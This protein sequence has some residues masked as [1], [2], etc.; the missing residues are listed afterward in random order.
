MQYFIDNTQG[1]EYFEF[2]RAQAFACAIEV[3]ARSSNLDVAFNL[4][5]RVAQE[6]PESLLN[7]QACG[8]ILC[9][10]FIRRLLDAAIPSS[11]R[12]LD[13]VEIRKALGIDDSVASEAYDTIMSMVKTFVGQENECPLGGMTLQKVLLE[14]ARTAKKS[15]RETASLP[16]NSGQIVFRESVSDA[17]LERAESCFQ[18]TLPPEYKDFL[19]I[20]NGWDG[21]YSRLHFR[22][23]YTVSPL[24]QNQRSHYHFRLPASRT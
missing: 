6:Q 10:H 13:L 21:E 22:R 24:K 2:R 14:Y 23:T 3:A 17:Q 9:R 7:P 20:S 19:R 1:K 5:K 18:I 4:M 11:Y 8:L 15:S 16:V 12:F